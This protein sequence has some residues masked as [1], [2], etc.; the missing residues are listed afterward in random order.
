MPEVP[1]P[2]QPENRDQE[3]AYYSGILARLP[4]TY[5]GN[6]KQ[7]AGLSWSQLY[8][9]IADTNPSADPKDLADAV[10]G[11]EAAQRL[12]SGLAAAENGLGK[13]TGTAE[14]SVAGTNFA[15]G[16][17][18]LSTLGDIDAILNA[19][20][21][22]L[23]KVSMWRSLG[24]IM[25]G[26]IFTAGGI[27]WWGK[28]EGTGIVADLT[29]GSKPRFQA[30]IIPL[31]LIGT[32]LYL[33]W[34]GVKYWEDEAVIWP[35]DPVKAVLQG[36]GLPA[37]SADITADAYLTSAQLANAAGSGSGGSAGSPTV[38]PTGGNYPNSQPIMA[39]LI[40]Q[41]YTPVAAAG[42]YGNMY[43]ESGGNPEAG[44]PGN[45]GLIQWTPGSEAGPYQ[46][47]MTGNPVYDLGRQ[48]ADVMQWNS[49]NGALPA[50][51]NPAATDP[52]SA[53]TWYMNQ[54][55]RPGIPALANRQSAATGVYRQYIAQTQGG[56]ATPSESSWISNVL[57]RIG[58]P[59]TAA[60]T[61][62]M[63]DWIGHESDYPGNGTTTGG[64]NNPLNTTLPEPGSVDY[65]S[66]GV[67][68]YPSASEGEQATSDTLENGDYPDILSRLRAGLGLR[69]GAG[70]GLDTWSGGGYDSV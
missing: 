58:A 18:G 28:N 12:G 69:T 22:Q 49:Q 54:A 48:L 56:G 29:R 7:Y 16:I 13:F 24:W 23:T 11:V 17:P 2:G 66:A 42:I 25:L 14:K 5:Q 40:A 21:H 62:S 1:P 52:S 63:T 41:G 30:P 9:D 68:N 65:N 3:I 53:A 67:Q 60:D 46:P 57:S 20:F 26:V 15:E 10:L 27:A 44:G 39:Y 32:G 33:L 35:S 19:L 70:E 36:K 55:E 43:Q 45:A 8:Q 31:A 6:L 64:L 4:G 59:S 34:F 38:P 51:M 37:R 50:M 47:V 61:A